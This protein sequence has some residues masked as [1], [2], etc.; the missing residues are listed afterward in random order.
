MI[1]KERGLREISRA[2]AIS[3]TFSTVSASVGD[4]FSPQLF[5]ACAKFLTFLCAATYSKVS[6]R[7]M[8]IHNNMFLLP[9]NCCLK[10]NV[11]NHFYREL[12][13]TNTFIFSPL[14]WETD[15][16]AMSFM[17]F[18]LYGS[19]RRSTDRTL[20]QRIPS[21]WYLKFSKQSSRL[22]LRA[23]Q[24][25][26]LSTVRF[27]VYRKPYR[28]RSKPST[29]IVLSI[30]T[31]ALLTGRVSCLKSEMGKSPGEVNNHVPPEAALPP[32]L[33]AHHALAHTR[34][35]RTGETET[36]SF[37]FS[38]LLIPPQPLLPEILV[39]HVVLN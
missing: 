16:C 32:P 13:L 25:C 7:F 15:I 19:S 36:A 37:P 26:S 5:T 8:L 11:L 2:A 34:I 30:I 21:H 17:P 39:F 18:L 14:S 33:Y 24:P 28:V 9:F 10:H 31:Q 22:G 29:V 12:F 4:N 6:S 20:A 1:R 27:W 38:H 23:L 3:N 35:Q